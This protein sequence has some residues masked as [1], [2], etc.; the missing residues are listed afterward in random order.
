MM[1]VASICLYFIWQ[2]RLMLARRSELLAAELDVHPARSWGRIGKAVQGRLE[3]RREDRCVVQPRPV[4]VHMA[5][6]NHPV[7]RQ[8]A[9]DDADSVSY[10]HLTLPTNREV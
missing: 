5:L 8:F 7:G 9:H 2:A 6:E 1:R 10:T 4:V 3:H